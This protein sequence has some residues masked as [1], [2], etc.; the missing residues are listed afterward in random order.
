MLI[1][2]DFQ[3]EPAL[4]GSTL[5]FGVDRKMHRNQGHFLK[6]LLQIRQLHDILISKT[7]PGTRG[8]FPP[9]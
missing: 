5:F 7:M 1:S 4:A 6:K 3:E 2:D 8:D 9:G